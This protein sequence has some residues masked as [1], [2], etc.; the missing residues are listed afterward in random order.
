MDRIK[1]KVLSAGG[2]VKMEGAGDHAVSLVYTNAYEK[3]DRIVL[4]T[5]GAPRHCVIHL[6][7]SLPPALVYVAQREIHYS[8]PFDEGRQVFSPK[9]FTGDCHLIRAR[10][11]AEGEVSARRCLSFNPYDQHGENGFFPHSSANVETRG[12]AVF[13]S[14]NAIDGMFENSSHGQWPYQS[15]GINRDPKAE[16]KIDFGRTVVIDEIRLTLR[17]DFPHDNYW[18]QATLGFSDGGEQ[19]VSL[20]KTGEPQVFSIP[21]RAVRWVV[22]K[23]LIQSQEASP[24]PALTQIEIWGVESDSR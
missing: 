4:E 1:L 24:F 11:A 5:D 8:I 9:S 19:T 3:G 6:E 15:W 13:A 23:D 16:L 21:K 7:D 12:E 2:E 22:L 18:T 14:Y 20:S 10:F 17:A